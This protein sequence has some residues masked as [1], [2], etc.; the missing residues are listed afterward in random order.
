LSAAEL[1]IELKNALMRKSK[2]LCRK[3]STVQHTD[4]NVRRIFRWKRRWF[5]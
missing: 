3:K 4:K 2:F 5:I 1:H